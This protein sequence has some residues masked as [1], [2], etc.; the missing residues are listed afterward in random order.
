MLEI[1]ALIDNPKPGLGNFSLSFHRLQE[2]VH[3]LW[4]IPAYYS[5]ESRKVFPSYIIEMSDLNPDHRGWKGVF[6]GSNPF[7][8]HVSF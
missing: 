5:R 4:Q 3:V 2:F 6:P 1:V 8:R 7:F